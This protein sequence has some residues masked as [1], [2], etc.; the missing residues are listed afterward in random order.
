MGFEASAL[1]SFSL[2]ASGQWAC[3]QSVFRYEACA[4]V[5]GSSPETQSSGSFCVLESVAVLGS[6][7]CLL[8]AMNV[9]VHGLFRARLLRDGKSDR[10]DRSQNPAL[11]AAA[12]FV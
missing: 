4:P 11:I 1:V 10:L 3:S 6:I 12:T 5:I 9:P 8:R 7:G 2:N